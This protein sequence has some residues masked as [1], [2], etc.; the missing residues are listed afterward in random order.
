MAA[1]G[2]EFYLRVVKDTFSTKFVRKTQLFL[3]HF[4]NSKIVQLKWYR[5]GNLAAHRES[6][7]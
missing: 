6:H 3:I 2:Y 4:R 7:R 1:R 5:Y